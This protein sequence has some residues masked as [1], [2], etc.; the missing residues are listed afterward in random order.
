MKIPKNDAQ[1]FLG[2]YKT[3]LSSVFQTE[4]NRICEEKYRL[5]KENNELISYLK[6]A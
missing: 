5:A 3:V 1:I 6:N 2:L 4:F